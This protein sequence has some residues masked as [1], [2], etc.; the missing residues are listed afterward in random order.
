MEI[1][2]KFKLIALWFSE[3]KLLILTILYIVLALCWL[4]F[5]NYIEPSFRLIGL[6][7]Q[8]CGIATV[9]IGFHQTRKQFNHKSYDQLFC[10]W[11][12]RFPIKPRPTFIEP[13]GIQTGISIGNVTLHTVFKLN[14]DTPLEQQLIKIEKEILFIQNQIDNQTN[15]NIDELSKLNNKLA[16]E[17][18]ERVQ[19][20][21]QTFKIIEATST[22]GIHI[23]FIG[24]IWLLLGVV[25]STASL[26]LSRIFG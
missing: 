11:L 23:S 7:L 12:K 15:K 13:E 25:F 26:E 2:R 1:I 3:A 6:L 4:N 9:I 24:T 18:N 19:S 22:G 16:V 10:N 14:P 20:I 5:F 8:I 21:N 17:K